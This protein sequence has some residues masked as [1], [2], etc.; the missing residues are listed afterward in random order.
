MGMFKNNKK[1]LARSYQ[2]NRTFD[3]KQ[4]EAT[5]NFTLNVENKDGLTDFLACLN[6]AVIDVTLVLANLGLKTDD[7]AEHADK[8]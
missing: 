4:G 2:N 7:Y 8:N 6:S 5:L 1:I 3:Y